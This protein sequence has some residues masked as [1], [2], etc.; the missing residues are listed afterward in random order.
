MP[1]TGHRAEITG[2]PRSDKSGK[3]E[4]RPGDDEVK[5]SGGEE[6]AESDENENETATGRSL[7]V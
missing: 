6:K 2:S 5:T 7:T 3:G 1:R 4:Y